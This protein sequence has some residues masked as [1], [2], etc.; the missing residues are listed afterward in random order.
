MCVKFPLFQCCYVILI[1]GVGIVFVDVS[2]VCEE[3]VMS[4]YFINCS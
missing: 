3:C 4:V 2:E 1:F